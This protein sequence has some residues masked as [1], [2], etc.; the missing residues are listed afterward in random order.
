MNKEAK[1]ETA[2]QKSGPNPIL[3]LIVVALV[4]VVIWSLRDRPD[5]APPPIA[6]E[7]MV[8]NVLKEVPVADLGKTVAIGPSA[9]AVRESGTAIVE[10]EKVENLA[11]LLEG[12]DVDAVADALAKAGVKHVLV[13][14]SIAK[15][16]PLPKN[17]V[18]NRLALARPAGRL[19]AVMMSKSVFLYK[20]GDPPLNLSTAAKTTL[21]AIARN[22]FGGGKGDVPGNAPEIVT[23]KGKWTLIL[24]VRPMQDRHISYHSITSSSLAAAAR[25]AGSKARRYYLKRDRFARKYGPLSTALSNRITIELEVAYDKGTFVGPRDETFVWRIIEP[26]IHGIRMNISGRLHY[27]PPWYTVANNL[28]LVTSLFERVVHRLAKLDDKNYWKRSDVPFDRFRTIHWRE[29]RPGG[30]IEDLYRGSPKMP[31][32]KDVTRENMIKSLVGLNDWLADNQTNPDGRYVYRYFPNK[33]EENNEY[34]M[35]RH[36]LGPFSMALTQQYSPNPKYKI[37]AEAGMKFIED[38]IRWGGKP[39]HGNG[40]IDETATSWMGKPLPGPDVALLEFAEPPSGDWS[41]KM[42]GVAVSILGYTE[43]K[44]A[45]WELSPKHEKVLQGL[46]NF[47]L[48]MQNKEDGNFHHYYVGTKSHYYGTRN[49][50]YPG[51]ILYAVARLYGE[52]KDERYRQAFKQSLKANLDWFKGQMDQRRP[53]G[54]YEEEHRKNLVQFQPWMAMAMDEM[55]RYDPDPSY[56]EASN[57]VSLWILDTYQFDYERSFYPDYMGGYFK[58]MEELPAMHTFV[59]TEGVAASFDLARRAGVDEKIVNRFRKGALLSA[60]FIIQQQARPGENDYYYPNPK[61]AKGAVRYCMN[62]NKQRIDYTYHALSSAY[63][64][65]RAANE[66]DYAFAQSIPMAK[67][68]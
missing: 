31:T 62:H 10:V 56:V 61:K 43:Y 67:T 24:T 41:T 19:S 7:P 46:A 53:D 34:N 35:V 66:E 36:C 51:E 57:L 59:Y 28:R 39:R 40:T 60:R 26:G 48:Y 45:G 15:R 8:A 21:T 49:S 30:P 33:D 20:L 42:G 18:K 11:Q 5:K 52:T 44:R 38:H 58:V 63:R 17:T 64:I 55:Y 23:K 32:M 13:D 22:T 37:K 65:I 6:D 54:T 4:I 68:W 2:T 29:D 27:L 9:L 50:I 16:N 3:I 14:P 25:K 12:R 47:L 1:K